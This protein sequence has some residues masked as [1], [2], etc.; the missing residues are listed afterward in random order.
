MNESSDPT[1]R[2]SEKLRSEL[3]S[4]IK[5]DQNE[6]CGVLVGK[7]EGEMTYL[8]TYVVRDDKPIKQSP[9]GIIRNTKS[10]YKQINSIVMNDQDRI[11]YIGEWH[12]HIFGSGQYSG[13][14]VLGM[15]SLINDPSYNAFPAFVLVIGVLPS[16][17]RAY[18][19]T[20]DGNTPRE[21]ILLD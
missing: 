20:R 19:F 2:I 10:V 3:F 21:M 12:S 13:I 7:R 9:F 16:T 8:V 6:H 11:D 18:L 5:D 14:D 4:S 15:R 17:L 1:L